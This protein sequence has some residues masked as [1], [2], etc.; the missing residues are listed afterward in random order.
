MMSLLEFL[1]VSVLVVL[2]FLAGLVA[3]V[4][5]G[6]YALVRLS[7]AKNAYVD[8]KE[9]VIAALRYSWDITRDHF[10]LTLWGNVV[11]AA[12]LLFGLILFFVGLVVAYPVAI[13]FQSALY[14]AIASE[15]QAAR[16]IEIQPEELPVHA[17]EEAA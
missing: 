12:I 15:Y 14:R 8:R 5:P 9:G 17:S 11:V 4:I 10:W 6:I 2:A 3:L 16:A 1:A 7:F 13:V